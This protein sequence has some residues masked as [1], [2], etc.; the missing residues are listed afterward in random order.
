MPVWLQVG[1]VEAEMISQYTLRE[2]EAAAL[3][4]QAAAAAAAGGQEGSDGSE[5]EDR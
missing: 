1:V 4:V 2:E 3:T 5:Q